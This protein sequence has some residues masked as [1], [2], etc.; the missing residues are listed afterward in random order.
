MVMIK[1]T[2]QA[3]PFDGEKAQ[4]LFRQETLTTWETFKATGLHLTADEADA[5]MTTLEQGEDIELPAA[6]ELARNVNGALVRNASR[7][8]C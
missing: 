7:N 4:E 2:E 1:R 8:R 5:W 6:L 3:P